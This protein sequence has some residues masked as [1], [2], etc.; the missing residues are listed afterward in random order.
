MRIL[1]VGNLAV[2]AQLSALGHEILSLAEVCPALGLGEPFD[3]RPLWRRYDPE[4]LLVVDPLGPQTLPHGMEDIPGP[5]VYWAV[6]VH[7]N[8]FWQRHYAQ[9]FDYVLVAQR[10]YVPLF[11]AA[12][13]PARWLP[14]GVFVDD[15]PSLDQPRTEDLVF[16]GA[17]DPRSRPK[18]SA[19][20]ALLGERF[21]LRVL[22]ATAAERLPWAAMMQQLATAKIVINESASGE[23]TFR[24][25]EAMAAGA[26][27]LTERVDSGVL[28]LFTP[29]VH[30]DVFT[31]ADVCEKVGHY[32]AAAERRTRIAAAGARLVRTRHTLA[33][34]A[35]E[36]AR[37]VEA[38][39][40]RRPVD[41][42][43]AFHTGMAF[44]LA[45]V[46]GLVEPGAGTRLAAEHLGRAAV[47]GG[48]AEAAIALAEL[49]AREGLVD[50]AL[51]A[52]VHA[53]RFAPAAVRAW[54]LAAD[55]EQRRGRT[56]AAAELLR[57]GVLATP[58]LSAETRA[59]ALAAVDVGIERAA[60][61]RALGDV[62]RESGLPFLPGL[63]PLRDAGVARTAADY[64][65]RALRLDAGDGEAAASLGTLLEF[66]GLADHAA[67]F[68]ATA[69]RATPADDA[70][71]AG[72][73]RAL[74]KSYR[75]EEASAT[76][77]AIAWRAATA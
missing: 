45:V 62:L 48:H 25:F 38:G 18:R 29:G 46:R 55:L 37:V 65:L 51:R 64:Y 70:R 42:E 30:L 10:D 61:A 6:D 31:P 58:A 43:A 23:L 2:A 33:A 11:V 21:A 3:V 15:L 49:S 72:L 75:L 27:L 16:V 50:G 28:D 34:R 26:L 66:M 17:V 47:D 77:A 44:H 36:L 12:G 68:Y 24:V 59:R 69:L 67:G 40:A 4:L 35:A 56:Q 57:A 32:L 74:W 41:V 60:T 71:R 20:L 52:L 9:L 73:A 39:I 22:G 13:V 5:R 19:L 14:W 63:V 7:L 76:A 53:R 8:W 1:F 54:F